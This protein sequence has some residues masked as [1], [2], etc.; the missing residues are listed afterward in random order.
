MERIKM[1]INLIVFP[2]G[3]HRRRFGSTEAGKIDLGST[4]RKS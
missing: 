2:V 4:A 1:D 3:G